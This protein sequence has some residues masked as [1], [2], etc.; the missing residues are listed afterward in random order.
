MA[1]KPKS[2]VKTKASIK[3]KAAVKPNKK[4]SSKQN[5]LS[6]LSEDIISNVGAGIYIV[7]HGKFIFTSPLYQRLTGYSATEIIGHNSFDHVHPDDKAMVRTKAIKSLKGESHSYEYR[8]IRKNGEE[9]WIL[10][11]VTSIIYK[12]EHATLGSFMDIT[13][14]KRIEDKLR[15]SEEKYRTILENIEDGYAEMDL[16]GNFIFFNEALCKIQGYPRNELMKLNYRDLMDEENA[17]KIFERYNK[18]YT[19]GE[20]EKE[21]PYEINTK[22]GDRRHLETSI[23]PMKDA[24]GWIFAFRGIVRDRTEHKQTEEALQKSEKRYRNILESIQEGYFELDLDGN[25]TFVN[26]ANSRFLGY[27]KEEMVGMNSRQHMDEETA[28]KLNQPY[29]E[30]YLTGKPLESLE[31]ESIRKD[32]TKVIY[33]TSVSLIRDSKGKPIGYRGVSRDVTGRKRMEEAL[34]KSE[35]KYRTILENIEE[36]YFEDDLSGKFTF[37]NDIMCSNLG[38]SRE[39]LIGMSYRQYT[40]EKNASKLRKLYEHLYKTGEPIKAFDLEA[41]NKNGII[42]IYETSAFIMRN[43]KGEPIGFRGVSRNITESKKMEE[44]LRQSEEKYRHILENMEEGYFEIDLVGNYTFVNNAECRNL[45]YP[46]EEL[47]GMN[48]R[49]YQDEAT[50]R[51]IYQV[52]NNMYKTGEPIKII[53]L[54]ITRKDGTK[55][56]NEI[57]VSLIRDSKGKKI[58]FSGVS[59]DITERKRSEESLKSNQEELIKKNQEL[60]ES[61]KNIQNTLERLGQAYE[62][63]KASQSK[64]LQQEKMA[65]VGQLAAGVAHEINNP[66]AFIASNLG[67]LDKYIHRLIDFIQ[68]QSEMIKSFKDADTIK[69]LKRKRKELKLDYVIDDVK[70]LITE[71]LDGSERVQKIVLGLNRFSRV[72]EEEYKDADINEC[73]ESAINIVWNELKYKSTLKKDYGK[74]PRTKCYP[75]QINQIFINLLINAVNSIEEQ[76]T[77]TIKTWNKGRSIWMVISDTGCGIP[78]ENQ[79]KIFEPFFTTKDVGKGTGLGLS[80]T[81]EIVQRHK[82]DITVKSEVGKGTTFTIRMPI[83]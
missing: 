3:P 16:H 1:V 74:L 24:A 19:T 63:L 33:E 70:G 7:Q 47:I 75:Q 38:Y 29:R 82:G 30:L 51:R 65:S 64:I 53:D 10:E 77:I 35:E 43:S 23:T 48:N 11:M 40:D 17:K 14:H 73:I 69:E 71:S 44:D 28:K 83:V 80:I 62:E 32:G 67:T 27:T 41:I 57:S 12:G 6:Q 55:K 9:M 79:S 25:Y 45:G 31:V 72:D 66:M 36:A 39:E 52:F 76:G 49:Q 15:R 20:S 4:I 78:R 8:F 59:R 56:F 42:M 22:S 50:S 68:T 13:E 46:K 58:G 37:V 21:V 61:R 60:E 2:S 34:R 26:E 54:E 81:Y 5:D 18:V